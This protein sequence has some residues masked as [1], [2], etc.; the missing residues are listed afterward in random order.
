MIIN[1]KAGDTKT[2]W[3]MGKLCHGNV[4]SF[5][6]KLF[7]LRSQNQGKTLPFVD[8]GIE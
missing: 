7:P 1:G 6:G 3:A 4:C 2:D 8:V 5:P